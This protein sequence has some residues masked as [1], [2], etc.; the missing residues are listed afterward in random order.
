[1]PEVNFGANATPVSEVVTEAPV[2]RQSE[3]ST[4]VSVPAT[5]APGGSAVLTRGKYNPTVKEI[6]WPR[7]NVV[8]NIGKL[9][10][11]FPPGSITFSQNFVIF[12]PGTA[13]VKGPTGQVVLQATPPDKPLNVV[14]IDFP[15]PTR[16]VEKKQGGAGKIFNTEEE[17]VQNGGTLDYQ[18]AASKKIPYYEPLVEAFVAIEQPASFPEKNAVF[19]HKVGDRR[20]A[21][22]LWA[23]KGAAYTSA[24]KKTINTER[25]MGCLK[26]GYSLWTFS[27]STI[28]KPY[29]TGNSAWVPVFLPTKETEQSVLDWIAQ[30][31]K[32][33]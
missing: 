26:D 4:P 31:Y 8:A 16:Y 20:F 24:I 22:A 27:V 33:E 29:R 12:S 21:L 5:I 11:Q 19:T 9:S 30:Y 15:N 10:T 18:E 7:I 23:F 25:L 1:M 17:V 2:P 28:L 3:T 13:E 32:S 14:V 6:I